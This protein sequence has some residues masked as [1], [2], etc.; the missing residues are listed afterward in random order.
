M[1]TSP[2]TVL[3]IDGNTATIALWIHVEL[4]VC[5]HSVN[6]AEVPQ[7]QAFKTCKAASVCV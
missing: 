1:F 2:K 6:V 7:A 4:P 5:F 3:K